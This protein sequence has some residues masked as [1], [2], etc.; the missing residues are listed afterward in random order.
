MSQTWNSE[1]ILEV[2]R[3]FQPACVLVAAAELDIFTALRGGPMDAR[4]LAAKIGADRRA[5]AVLL[6][7]LAALGLLV[8]EGARY[9]PAP[10]TTDA[11]AAGGSDSALAMVQHQGNCLRRWGQLARVVKTGHAAER[12]P[13]VRGEA[14]DLES[15]V[16]AMNEINERLA[17]ALV[18]RI[19]PPR[20]R[21]ILDVG[22][23]T[24]TWTI[25]LLRAAPAARATLF[26]LPDV[27]PL[28]RRRLGDAGLLARVDFVA[29]DFYSDPLPGG[30][31]LI[32]LSAIVH[33]NSR[34]QNRDLFR[35]AL[36]A[37]EPGG[38]VA[39]RDFVMDESRTRPPGGALFAVNMLVGTPAGG[40]FTSGEL[41]E[42]LRA[43]GFVS[44][45]LAFAGQGM[46]SL[47]VA[48]KGA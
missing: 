43:A 8:K 5:L 12:E 33:Q 28:A 10:G 6:D 27:V 14:G 3:G 16:Q 32:W 18:A 1:K 4:T 38:R 48:E 22:G 46:D 20:F 24:G 45:A 9:R 23:A 21:R 40:T 37:L 29:G 26:D 36:A 7:A 19:D 39:I 15:F 25:A 11:L 31:D 17:P 34:E 42:D 30:H 47:V 44:P 2:V 35:K 13:S 41:S